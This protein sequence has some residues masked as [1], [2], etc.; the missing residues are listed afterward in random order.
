[1]IGEQVSDYSRGLFLDVDCL[2]L[3][4][5]DHLFDLDDE[6]ETAILYQVEGGQTMRDSVLS[7]YPGRFG[8]G[9]DWMTRFLLGVFWWVAVRFNAEALSSRR[10]RRE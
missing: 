5:L 7:G 6:G 1:V 2:A 9:A 3:R 4:N 10:R 8:D